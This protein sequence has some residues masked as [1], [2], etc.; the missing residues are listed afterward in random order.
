MKVIKIRKEGNY[1]SHGIGYTE[2]DGYADTLDNRY[3]IK[4][5]ISS[6]LRNIKEGEQYQVEVNGINKGIFTKTREGEK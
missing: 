3:P 2:H 4:M 6:E 5:A 1:T